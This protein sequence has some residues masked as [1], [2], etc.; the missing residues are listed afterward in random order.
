VAV[1]AL[2]E[3]QHCQRMVRATLA[4]AGV[5]YTPLGNSHL[6]CFSLD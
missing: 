1:R 6:G 4:L 5:R 3:L 2:L